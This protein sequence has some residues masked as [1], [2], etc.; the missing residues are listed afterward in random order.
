MII[1]DAGLAAI[2][3]MAVVTYLT[4]IV[5][6]LL[7]DHLGLAGRARVA[8]DAAPPAILTALVAPAMLTGGPIEG[9]AG[10]ITL[11]AAFRLPLLGTVLVGVAT[12]VAL[13][14]LLGG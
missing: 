1:D 6:L 13:R 8:L 10:L 14:G 2:L 12:I 9:V 5:G 11:I 4:R 3:L 7:V